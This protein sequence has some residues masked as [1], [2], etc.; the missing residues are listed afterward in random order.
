MAESHIERVEI[1]SISHLRTEVPIDADEGLAL[2]LLLLLLRRRGA[3]DPAVVEG[4]ERVAMECLDYEG[5]GSLLDWYLTVT[6]GHHTST[7]AAYALPGWIPAELRTAMEELRDLEPTEG[8]RRAWL[9]AHLVLSE[10]SAAFE[11]ALELSGSGTNKF[12]GEQIAWDAIREP[13]VAWRDKLSAGER[14]DP[15]RVDPR[16]HMRDMVRSGSDRERYLKRRFQDLERC[17][18]ALADALADLPGP[19]RPIPVTELTPDLGSVPTGLRPLLVACAEI[20]LDQGTVA[21]TLGD[22]DDEV[23]N[24]MLALVE[25]ADGP[26]RVRLARLSRHAGLTVEGLADAWKELDE[27]DAR[28]AELSSQGVDVEEILYLIRVDDDLAGASAAAEAAA[29]QAEREQRRRTLEQRLERL[30][31]RAEDEAPGD[32]QIASDIEMVEADLADE[33]FEDVERGLR[34]LHR[35]LEGAQREQR[36]EDLRNART[37][38]EEVEGAERL[39][40]DLDDAIASAERGDEPVTSELVDTFRDRANQAWEAF[41]DDVRAELEAALGRLRQV[42]E[43]FDP[44]ERSQLDDLLG[45]AR[46][47]LALEEIRQARELVREAMR[48]IDR[49]F[50]PVWD[51]ERAEEELVE[52]IE[53]FLARRGQFD[54]IDVRRLHVSLK[55]RRFVILAGLTGSGKST[56]ARGYAEAIGATA[57][58]VRRIAVRPNWVDESEVLGF[59]NPV[60]N[61]FQPGWLATLIRDCGR[62]PELPHFLILDE[63]NLAPVEYYLADVLSALEDV[64][65]PGSRPTLALYPPESEPENAD[66]WPAHIELPRNLFII[67]TVNI[68]ESTRAISDR[69]LDRANVIQLSLEVDGSHHDERATDGE[70]PPWRVRM[71]AWDRIVRDIPS[72]RYH[73]ELVEIAETLTALRIGMGM[74][75]HLEIERFLSNA[76]GVL[77]T[78]DALDLA[79]LQRVIPKIRGFRGEL[80]SALAELQRQFEQV[81]AH[82]CAAVVEAWLDEGLSDETFIDGTD[83]SVGLATT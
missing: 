19:D 20:L 12:T 74:R 70:E 69:V 77:E 56:I 37:R 21:A 62:D 8:T 15:P 47:M 79:L 22:L 73:D 50:V 68:D 48:S 34:E 29:Q 67:G 16:R 54:P 28:V 81:S 26:L 63:M 4:L 11:E 44:V 41:Q 53:R 17:A 39:R 66:T 10:C 31:R 32:T 42:P 59:V 60:S 9:E 45:R 57:D 38:L 83:A 71:A 55:T 49:R 80:A 40:A 78:T 2:S 25:E 23:E 76:E 43:D 1:E 36:L 72:P 33:Q 51:G 14:H 61:R 75:S 35:L 82:R 27:L 24:R 65:S 58:R 3:D 64:T 52:H 13:F 7:G 18:R 30:R 6:E 46:Q 5:V